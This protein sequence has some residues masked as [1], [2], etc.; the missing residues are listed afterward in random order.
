MFLDTE[1]GSE[2]EDPVRGWG[3]SPGVPGT[4]GYCSIASVF[5]RDSLALIMQNPPLGTPCD[6]P[7]VCG[8]M[9]VPPRGWVLAEDGGGEGMVCSGACWQPAPRAPTR[10]TQG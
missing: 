2:D 10:L 5:P 8:R 4:S 9:F 3:V 7:A 6:F 1:V